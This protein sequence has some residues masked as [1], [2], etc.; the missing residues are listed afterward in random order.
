MSA[1]PSDLPAPLL[2]PEEGQRVRLLSYNVQVGINS[3]RPHHYFTGSWR[4]LLPHPRRFETL[5]QIAALLASHDLVALQEVDAGS[6]R[7]GFVNL[8]EYLADRAGFPFWY[9]QL[10]R[11]LGKIAQH[12]N[13]FLCRFRPSEVT[14]HRLPGLIPGRG[15]LLVRFGSGDEALV[16]LLLH[17]AL[18]RRA[19]FQQ[20]E[21]I[22]EVVN[23]FRHVVVMGDLN[24]EADS[25]EME[26]LFRT[27]RLTTAC[28][29]AHTFPS[30]R[31]NRCIDHILVTPELTVTQNRVIREAFSDH[32]PVAMEVVLPPSLRLTS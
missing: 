10:N 11:D 20:L 24:C 15:G 9:H 26:M 23:T 2:N 28:D 16:V 7:T 18:S 3:H 25:P 13:G 14:E 29:T 30:W 27:T 32:L 22:S 12:S 19:R 4:H 17:L 21:Y 31:P 1:Q 6:R 8:T 5:D